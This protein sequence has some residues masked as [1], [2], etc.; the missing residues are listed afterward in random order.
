MKIR[1]T[2]LKVSQAMIHDTPGTN[3]SVLNAGQDDI[4]LPRLQEESARISS[5]VGLTFR[6]VVRKGVQR[7]RKHVG[8]R[9]S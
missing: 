8:R 4:E 9:I 7:I 5:K 1:D 6:N 3:G 2:F